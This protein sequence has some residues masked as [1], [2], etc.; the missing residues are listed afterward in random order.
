MVFE[1]AL[2]SAAELPVFFGLAPETPL[3]PATEAV[4]VAA[5]NAAFAAVA[6]LTTALSIAS[7]AIAWFT[8]ERR[9]APKA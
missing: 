5:T 2:G 9:F 8:L 1:R 7:A 3:D 4:R 6:W